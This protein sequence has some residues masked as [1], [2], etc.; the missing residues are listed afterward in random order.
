[1]TVTILWHWKP[2]SVLPLQQNHVHAQ[3]QRKCVSQHFLTSRQGLERETT[4][5]L[6]LGLF[7]P[8]ILISVLSQN[9]FGF[10]IGQGK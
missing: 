8:L 7:E 5:L 1:M 9:A 4:L 10:I 2:V 3:A 6:T